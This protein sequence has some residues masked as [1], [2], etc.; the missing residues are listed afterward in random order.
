MACF[1]PVEAW[2]HELGGA[3]YFRE[4]KNARPIRVPCGGCLGCRMDRRREWAIRCV[5]EAQMHEASAFVTLTYDDDH[6]P[7]GGT[8]NYKHFQGFMHRLRKAQAKRSGPKLRFF[9]CGEY[10]ETTWRPHYHALLFGLEVPDL[11]NP[12]RTG[13]SHYI[14][15][16]EWL[17]ALWKR[18]L[19]WTGE[20]TYES[21]GYCA[22]Y[23]LKKVT[24]KRA[25]EYY[26]KTDQETGEVFALVAPFAR[27]SLRPGIGAEWHKKYSKT[28]VTPHD[29]VV[30][31]GREMPTPK[32]YDRLLS[33]ESPD[34]LEFAKFQ[35]E[36]K[37]ESYLEHTTPERLAT[38]E[39]C[40]T[41]RANLFKRNIGE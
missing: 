4:V 29:R 1:S 14:Y 30:L 41:A 12:K 7:P 8:L 32:Y 35:R 9:M 15:Q 25:K 40:A 24:G 28:D 20:V 39:V 36:V 11:K 5:H 16:S 13:A 26:T 18:G 17:D 2:Q 6:L 27:M 37:S 21:A 22:G 10:G 23:A 19:T 34:L 3:L 33:R 38:R 31:D